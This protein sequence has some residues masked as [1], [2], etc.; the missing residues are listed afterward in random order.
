MRRKVSKK[1]RKK[2]GQITVLPKIQDSL[3]E[4][5]A[6]HGEIMGGVRTTL[7][8]AIRIGE[9]LTEMKGGLKHGQWLAWIKESLPFDQ[10]T[11]WNYMRVFER[12]DKLG[13]IPNLGPSDAYKMLSEG[14]KDATAHVSHNSG[15]NEWYTPQPFIEAAREAMGSIDCDPASSDTANK[16][17]KAEKYFTKDEDGLSK[18]WSGNVWLNPPYA[19]PLIDQFSEAVATKFSN[20]EIKQ[21]LIL[22]NNA[23]ETEWF[24]RMAKLSAAICFPASRIKFIDTKGDA[25]GAPLQGQAI[26]YLGKDIQRFNKA[27]NSFGFILCKP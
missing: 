18:E 17:V 26:L 21:A 4:V 24:S 14:T 15:E 9:L 6:L 5:I 22:V 12:K 10:K 7:A 25:S 19:Q 2:H 1:Q 16:T 20:G 11:A 13:T 8:K 23:T 27:Y 3:K